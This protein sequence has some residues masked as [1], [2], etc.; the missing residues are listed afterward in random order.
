MF[1][2]LIKMLKDDSIKYDLY[3]C[4]SC[5]SAML[6]FNYNRNYQILI[7]LTYNIKMLYYTFYINEKKEFD[8]YYNDF[9][10]KINNF[11]NIK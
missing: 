5:K 3:K 8:G 10:E 11:F 4:N 6:V 1:Y 2:K 7:E 9:E